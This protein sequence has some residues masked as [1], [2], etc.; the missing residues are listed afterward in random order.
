MVNFQVI[1]LLVVLCVFYRI[2]E[3]ACFLRGKMAV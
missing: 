2:A 3:G 1:Y